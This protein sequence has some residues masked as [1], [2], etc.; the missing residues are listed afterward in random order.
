M[1]HWHD[2]LEIFIAIIV[3][4]DP[5]GAI[6]IFVGLT[7]GQ[8]ENERAHTA[9]VA[10]FSMTI[11]LVV[12]TLVG[13]SLLRLFGISI[14]SFQVGGGIL[15]LLLAI[16]MMN[17]RRSPSK[18][19]PEE[20]VEAAGKENVAVVPLAVPLLAGPAAISTVIIYA[21]QENVTW[22]LKAFLLLCI[23]LVAILVW[24]A[25]RVSIPLSR[26]L[27]QTA[28]NNVTRLLGLLLAAIA[29]EFMT[30]GLAKLFPGLQ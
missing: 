22:A 5:L 25:F 1:I 30:T 28:M 24:I 15:L 13:K 23:L 2:Y 20:E 3:I 18:Q 10:V 7:A 21:T 9:R 4:V 19:T 6:P 11:L 14:E 26:K 17:A 8:S 16:S 29:V 27:G 12:A